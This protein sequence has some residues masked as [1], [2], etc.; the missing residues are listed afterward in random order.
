[1]RPLSSGISTARACA[2]ARLPGLPVAPHKSVSIYDRA[3]NACE[4]GKF[5]AEIVSSQVARSLLVDPQ[6]SSRDLASPVQPER[7]RCGGSIR[8][9]PAT[10]RRGGETALEARVPRVIRLI[11]R[12]F[13]S[14]GQA[15]GQK[16][17]PSFPEGEG[18]EG[19]KA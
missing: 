16:G 2:R 18:G 7:I 4:V 13:P 17:S 14:R 15:A 9:A 5:R 8:A 19:E 10:A 6:P 3:A 12:A 1:M 11:L